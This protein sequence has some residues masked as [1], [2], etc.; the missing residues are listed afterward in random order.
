[1][2]RSHFH[3]RLSDTVYE[4]TEIG[5]DGNISGVTRIPC[6]G[7]TLMKHNAIH[8]CYYYYYHYYCYLLK[9]SVTPLFM[10]H[11]GSMP[12]SQGLSN[13]RIG[14]HFFKT[15]SNI[16]SHL[17]LDLPKVLFPTVL[18]ALLPSSYLAI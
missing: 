4:Y 16:V 2:D 9:L 17:L 1:M 6:L 5:G 8:D 3:N 14:T 12:H 13:N 15:H 11:G 7:F 10:K 18:K